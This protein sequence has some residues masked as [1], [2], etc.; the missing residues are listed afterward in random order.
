MKYLVNKSYHLLIIIFT[1]GLVFS[2]ENIGEE[3]IGE[4]TFLKNL[5]PIAK[6]DNYIVKNGGIL[7]VDFNHGVLSNDADPGGGAMAAS[8][9]VQTKKGTLTLNMDGSFTYNHDGSGVG[10]DTFIYAASTASCDN[11]SELIWIVWDK[12][13]LV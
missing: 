2:C 5:C 9:V 8:I 6:G 3:E 7:N 10:E 13:P 11:T 4:N 1:F 12:S